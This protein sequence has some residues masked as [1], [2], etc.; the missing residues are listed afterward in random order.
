MIKNYTTLTHF[1]ICLLKEKNF[2]INFFKLV[3]FLTNHFLVVIKNF[4]FNEIS[5]YIYFLNQIGKPLTWDMWCSHPQ[6]NA[7]QIVTNK[8]I[9]KNMPGLF[10]NPRLEWHPDG[11]WSDKPEEILSFYCKTAGD[12]ITQFLD[13]SLALKYIKKVSDIDINDIMVEISSD[14]S[15]TILKKTVHDSLPKYQ[16]DD[17]SKYRSTNKDI[18]KSKDINKEFTKIKPLIQKHPITGVKG[19]FF[20]KFNI[21]KLFSKKTQKLLNKEFFKLCELIFRKEFIYTHQWEKGDLI[22]CDQ[23]LTLHRRSKHIG[24][25]ELYRSALWYH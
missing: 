13:T 3:D 5:E 15:K 22:L 11:A 21:S 20:P 19:L 8:K 18:K 25:R 6:S 16:E 2:N 17:L 1:G 9:C 14:N 23:V 10:F 24:K 7:I 4:T 12:S